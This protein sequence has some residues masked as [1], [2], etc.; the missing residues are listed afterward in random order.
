VLVTSSV[1]AKSDEQIF[2]AAENYT[3]Y[4][5]TSIEVPFVEDTAGTSMLVTM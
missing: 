5:V 2:S 3:A 4:I 1:W